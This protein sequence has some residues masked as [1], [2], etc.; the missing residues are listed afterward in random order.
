MSRIETVAV[1]RTYRAP[2][3]DIASKVSP[4]YDIWSLGCVLLEFVTWYLLGG[5]GV[6]EFSKRR[7][8]EDSQEIHEDRFFNFVDIA[9]EDAEPPQMGARAKESVENVGTSALGC[10]P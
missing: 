9:K 8:A 1:S 2:E 3:Y 4:S 10:G 7:A 6:E 5:K